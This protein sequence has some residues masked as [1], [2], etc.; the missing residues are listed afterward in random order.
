MYP[1]IYN[2][3][4]EDYDC[5]CS[6]YILF[7]EDGKKLQKVYHMTGYSFER[8]PIYLYW[9][10]LSIKKYHNTVLSHGFWKHFELWLLDGS[11]N[12]EWKVHT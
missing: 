9:G 1:A 2:E 8:S 12:G 6:S 11:Q 7:N 10:N 5:D 3:R 4:L